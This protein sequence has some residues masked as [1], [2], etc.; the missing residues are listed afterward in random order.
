M[1]SLSK[2]SCTAGRKNGSLGLWT[3]CTLWSWRLCLMTP[4]KVKL[5]MLMP[6]KTTWL[7]LINW[8]CC[9]TSH[10]M[11]ILIACKELLIVRWSTRETIWKEAPWTTLW[12]WK[13]LTALTWFW[14]ITS[15]GILR[16]EILTSGR[17]LNA[18]RSSPIIFRFSLKIRSKSLRLEYLTSDIS[19]M[20]KIWCSSSQNIEK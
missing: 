6:S 9:T 10:A 15:R 19:K 11:I 7:C 1:Q 12:T 8:I 18:S 14:T 2:R 16:L 5:S 13:A 3:M 4:G 20:G 17:S